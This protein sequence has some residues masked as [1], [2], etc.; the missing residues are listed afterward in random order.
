[1]VLYSTELCELD[2]T[3]FLS[4]V[5]LASKIIIRIISTRSL[6]VIHPDGYLTKPIGFSVLFRVSD[7]G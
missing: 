4:N 2:N 6:I 3:G 5:N 1:M 7:G